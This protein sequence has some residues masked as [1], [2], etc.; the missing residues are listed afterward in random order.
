MHWSPFRTRLSRLSLLFAFIIF[1]GVGAASP[2]VA[3]NYKEPVTGVVHPFGQLVD[4]AE[5]VSNSKCNE[6]VAYDAVSRE[7]LAPFLHK[8][9]PAN[10]HK[11]INQSSLSVVALSV[12]LPTVNVH[13]MRQFAPKFGRE[14]DELQA[15]VCVSS[16]RSNGQCKRWS[17]DCRADY[18]ET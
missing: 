14:K 10:V 3:S 4:S 17:R 12:Q 5:I 6:Y 9:A 7:I 15:D 1:E 16:L 18:R 2:D 11:R 13:E 8:L